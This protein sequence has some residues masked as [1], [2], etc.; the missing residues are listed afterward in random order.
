MKK[1]NKV[2]IIIP[3]FNT[4]IFIHET[5]ASCKNQTYPNIEIIV[6]DDCSSDGT[7]LEALKTYSGL[8]LFKNK[9]NLGISKTINFGANQ[10][11]GDFILF[12]GHDDILPSFHVERM[13]KS[14]DADTS[15]V[16]CNALKID[17][18]NRLISLARDPR[19]QRSKTQ[20]IFK[21]LAV[22]N[23]IQSCGLMINRH[24]FVRIDGWDESYRLF[25]EWLSYIKL[26]QLGNV[27]YC[28]DTFAYYR[29]HKSSTMRL[30]NRS[31]VKEILS[32]KNTCRT[33]ALQLVKRSDRSIMFWLKGQA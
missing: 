7:T 23:F 15:F 3:T 6:V 13:V 20:K 11:T 4:G 16:H 2:S 29:V 18:Y 26:A 28:Q 30:I 22:E 9:E 31:Y 8:R 14:F 5:I 17:Q 10:A 32:Y 21:N 12:L 1:F 19:Q 25:G 27:K 33:K 24:M